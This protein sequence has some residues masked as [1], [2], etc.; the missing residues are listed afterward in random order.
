MDECIYCA[1]CEP[2]LPNIALYDCSE[3][4]CMSEKDNVKTEGQLLAKNIF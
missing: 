3:V 2:E 4:C 1:A